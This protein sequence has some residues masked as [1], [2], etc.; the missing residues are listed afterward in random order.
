MPSILPTITA[1]ISPLILGNSMLQALTDHLQH[2]K[3]AT[4]NTT[5]CMMPP[6][7]QENIQENKYPAE[8]KRTEHTRTEHTGE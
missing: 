3:S 1:H 6:I 5:K 7:T 8:Q 2:S 4:E